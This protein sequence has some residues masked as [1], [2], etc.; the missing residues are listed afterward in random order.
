MRGLR[1]VTTF[2]AVSATAKMISPTV[3]FRSIAT[4]LVRKGGHDR[5]MT[6][7]PSRYN[8]QQ[9]KDQLHF[10]IF[11]GVIPLSVLVFLVNVFV[12]PATLQ[13]IPEGY[14]PKHYEYSPHPVTRFLARYY[15]WNPQENYERN[16][17]YIKEQDEIRKMR[18]MTWKVRDLMRDRGDYPNF[19]MTKGIHGKY[20]QHL[21]K[22][23]DDNKFFHRGD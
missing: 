20:M 16:L 15:Y 8:W 7:T 4:S 19:F 22:E 3:P 6:I 5:I 18:L 14:T 1:P 9:Y 11:L 13:E 23:W 2:Q 21:I 10:Y 17:H 12:G